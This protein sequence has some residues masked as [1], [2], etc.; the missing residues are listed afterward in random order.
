[1]KTE[2]QCQLHLEINPTVRLGMSV[3]W[4][5]YANPVDTKNRARKP[6]ENAVIKFMVGHVRKIPKQTV[7]HKPIDSNQA[8]S[9][10]IGEKKDVEVRERFMQI[11]ELVIAI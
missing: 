6:Q 9:E 7:M 1:M 5:K 11:Y 10:V 2:N 3:D 4:H 8:H